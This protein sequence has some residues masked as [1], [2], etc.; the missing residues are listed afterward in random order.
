MGRKS[1]DF[2]EVQITQEMAVMQVRSGSNRASLFT[3]QR[4]GLSL[5]T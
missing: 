4:D 2:Y 5:H 1:L 3:L